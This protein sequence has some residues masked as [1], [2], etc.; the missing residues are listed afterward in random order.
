MSFEGGYAF[1]KE[2]D[3]VTLYDIFR[4]TDD[5]VVNVS[6]VREANAPSAQ[7]QEA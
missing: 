1:V 4:A 7:Y 6:C 2:A 3:K 5:S